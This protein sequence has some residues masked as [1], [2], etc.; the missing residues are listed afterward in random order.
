MNQNASF[1]AGAEATQSGTTGGVIGHTWGNATSADGDDSWT[2]S[3]VGAGVITLDNNTLHAGDTSSTAEQDVN[4]VGLAGDSA[5]GSTE[6]LK[7][8]TVGTGLIGGYLDVAQGTDTGSSAEAT[9]SGTIGAVIGHTWGN[10]TAADGDESWTYSHVGAGVVTLDSNTVHAGDTSSTADQDVNVA[11]LAG[12]AAV[13]SA[14]GLKNATVGAELIGGYLDMAQGTDTG[15]SAAATQNG[16]VGAALGQT[17]GYAAAADGDDSWTSAHVLTGLITLNS[18]TVHAGD[19]SSTADQDVNIAG[20]VGD[21]TTGS[22]SGPKSGTVGSKFVGGYLDMVQGTDTGFSAAAT[23]SGTVGAALGH[24]WGYATAADGDDSWTSADVLAGLITLD[25]NTVHAGDTSSTADQ[26]VNVAGLAGDSAVGST[27][28]LK[29][30]TAGAGFTG[31]YLDMF[32]GTDT[33]SSAAATQS[34]T[35]GAVL[36]QTWGNATA[37]DG[38]E[39]WTYSN[40]GV[41]VIALDSNTAHAGDTSSSA[42]QDANVAGL[43]GDAAVGSTEGLKYATVGAGLIGG[44]LDVAQGTDTSAS[45]HAVQDGGMSAALGS[46]WG[47]AATGAEK[48]WTTADVVV[49]TMS[50]DNNAYAG[51]STLAGQT[52]D[53]LGLA[54]NATAG[55]ADGT[56]VTTEGAGIILG[57]LDVT[58]QADTDGSAH[59][60]QSGTLIAGLGNTWGEATSG[61]ERSWTNGTLLIGTMTFDNT[62]YAGGSTTAGQTLN[63]LGLAGN[64]SAG[65]TDGTNSTREGAGFM[66]GY[67]AMTQQVN[68][69]ASAHATQNGTLIAGLGNTW[70]E[71][72]SG[73]ERAWTNG[74]VFFGIITLDDNTLTA[75]AGT[76]ADQSLSIFG[77]NGSASSGSTDGTNT[78]EVGAE[79]IGGNLSGL[80]VDSLI[81][82]IGN[83]TL[84]NVTA[85]IGGT[86]GIGGGY[87]AMDQ[88][89]DTSASTHAAQSGTLAAL[90]DGRTWAEATSGTDERSWTT[91]NVTTGVIFMNSNTA[92]AGAG[93]SASDQSLSIFGLNGNASSGSTDGTNSAGV[94]AEISGGNLSSLNINGLINLI[95]NPTLENVTALIGGTEGIGGG[96]LDMDQQADTGASAHATQSGTVVAFADGRTW[97]EATTGTDDRSWTVANVT[98]GIIMLNSNT[99]AAGAGTS[100]S[101]QN[102]FVAGLN[103]SAS[104]GSTDATNSAGVGARFDGSGSPTSLNMEGLVNLI[105]NPSPTNLTAWI[106]GLG[107]VGAGYLSMDQQTDTSASA[108]AIQSDSMALGILPGG[109]NVYNANGS[110]WGE[111]S[112]VEN[113]SWTHAEVSSTSLISPGVITV[114]SNRVYAG[115][116]GTNASQDV[117]I[118]G[119]LG[120]PAV[121]GSAAVGSTESTKSAVVG[122]NF[123]SGSL[124]LNQQTDTGP[125]AD[126]SQDG[127]VSGL[128][129]TGHTWGNATSG[130]GDQSWTYADVSVGSIDVRSNTVYADDTSTDATQNIKISDITGILGAQSGS[131]AAGSSEGEKS[132]TIG[133]N[134]AGSTLNLG[135][136]TMNQLTNTSASASAFQ[137]G[138]V[139]SGLLGT[140][141]TWGNDTSGDGDQSWTYADVLVG[142]IDVRSNTVH[143]DDTSTDATQNIKIS[144]ITGILGAQSGSAAAGSSEGGKSATVGANFAG[145]TLN[146][147]SL[148]MT[149]LTNT[150]ASASAFQ[151]GTVNS[152]LLGTGHT[153][154]NATS[155]D[156][157][158]SW[159]Y[160]D[161]SVGSIDVRSNTVQ[162]DDTSTDATQNIRISDITGILGAQSGSAAAGSSEGGKS[163]TVGA[164][165]TGG[166]ANL[167]SLTMNQLTNT[168]ASASAFQSGTV[169]SGLLGTGYTWGN[170]TSGDGDQSW[171]YADVVTGSITVTS[172]RVSAGDTSSFATQN[173][174]LSGKSG[175][176]AVGSTEGTTTA[177]VGASFSGGTAN[178]GSLVAMNQ[179]T[180]T[181]ASAS[182]TQSGTVNSGLISATGRTWGNTTAGDGD[183]SW[184][185][186]DVV[187]GSI[188]VTS[189]TVS[190]GDTST[191]GTQSL[192]VSGKSGD[193][194]VGSTEGT[195]SATVGASFTGGTIN[196]GSLVAMQQETGTIASAYAT[197]NG[198]VNSGIISATGRTWGNAVAGD[199]DRSF[200]NA[201]LVT[202]TLKINTNS[203]YAG[204]TCTTASQS[205]N[206]SSV[207]GGSAWTG[208][209]NSVE[210]NYATVSAGYLSSGVYTSTLDVMQNTVTDPLVI[211]CATA[212]QY[213]KILSYSTTSGGAWTHTAAGNDT[214]RQVYADTIAKSGTYLYV[215]PAGVTITSNSNAVGG[216]INSTA[217]EAKTRT[218]PSGIGYQAPS[219]TTTAF[220][221]NGAGQNQD[222]SNNANTNA[223][224]WATTST[225]FADVW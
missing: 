179:Q 144:D 73:S 195:K 106:G 4:L 10:A 57:T 71:A 123:T 66:L 184:T 207:G 38:D 77:L 225:R 114:D 37:A 120:L 29:Y 219:S 23:Q 75:G 211:G 94:G 139:N 190:A 42:D 185:Y 172:N 112:S 22:S 93:T 199:G 107:D 79:I 212:Q 164:S 143:A 97:G 108:H 1:G 25:T 169:N 24:T 40:V 46:T 2:Y 150:S 161:V 13:G 63:M 221:K 154:G 69:S 121:S 105:G 100:A 9:Q 222:P 11:G 153:W 30:A 119:L 61:D 148:T 182:A 99:A 102:V 27:E 60:T 220:A 98:T 193:S 186:A 132:A 208:S 70:G 149:Q 173:V 129:G 187:T 213:A 200:T 136:L 196:A 175:D 178:I 127:T 72:A 198:T 90:G 80:D 95:G 50:F 5:V 214:T 215:T 18:N 183:Q 206:L 218:A 204:D 146:L 111:A 51:A 141:H 33:G 26:D 217:F 19:S 156:G 59:A 96:Y 142:S 82:L 41:G 53:I 48:S 104:A 118:A 86:D 62:A 151:S 88:Q 131:A 15:S 174:G 216:L 83:P 163:A 47:E 81:N 224:A 31:G 191:Y 101:D 76:S 167:G 39:S 45:A 7:Y 20:L 117:G 78:A 189:N 155:G 197:Q 223:L 12:D 113:R 54:G 74:S 52:L 43:A 126:A 177:I 209:T 32:Q 36:G 49:G 87:L 201:T 85:L 35:V 128:L 21:A 115:D 3:H 65:S 147:G 116:D 134:F 58:Q 168:S 124:T 166:T 210:G 165:F 203:V 56:N 188:T 194:A 92:A 137:S 158:Q 55:S 110:T 192:G 152:G 157:D 181:T 67:L 91:A 34:G 205:L 122:A 103:G 138:T 14:E 89:A 133:A 160:S 145:S 159:T 176:A 68:T 109:V 28:G 16:T 170:A 8:A 202:G 84:E 171:T 125:G 44:S 64:V 162:A 140:G 180:S 6:G 130:D 17:W 135:S